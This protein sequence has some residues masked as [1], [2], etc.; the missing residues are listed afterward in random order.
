MFDKSTDADAIPAGVSVAKGRK[1]CG[2][3]GIDNLGDQCLFGDLGYFEC[4]VRL[5]PNV[6]GSSNLGT[7]ILCRRVEWPW[8][9]WIVERHLGECCI[10]GQRQQEAKVTVHTSTKHHRDRT[11]NGFKFIDEGF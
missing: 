7:C 9:H 8:I 3:N 6:F 1:V 10:S 4:E 2:T 11:C 5:V